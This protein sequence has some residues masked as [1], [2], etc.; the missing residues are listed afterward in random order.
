[1][2]G[3]D[4]IPSLRLSAVNPTD[5]PTINAEQTNI[6]TIATTGCISGSGWSLEAP[7]LVPRSTLSS[8]G[9]GKE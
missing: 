3:K 8:S 7:L 9:D 6:I 4:V 2:G 5:K 1:M